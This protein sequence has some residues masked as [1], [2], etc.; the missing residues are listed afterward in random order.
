MPTWILRK[1][2]DCERLGEPCKCANP[3]DIQREV[4]V[5]TIDERIATMLADDEQVESG[6][7][8]SRKIVSGEQ[9]VGYIVVISSDL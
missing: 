9:T 6:E 1:N 5:L 4:G 8:G 3:H 2:I 7:A